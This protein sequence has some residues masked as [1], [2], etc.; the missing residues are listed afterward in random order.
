MFGGRQ[1][2]DDPETSLARCIVLLDDL[3]AYRRKDIEQVERQ[4]GAL[5]KTRLSE[6]YDMW[7]KTRPHAERIVD[8]P[9]QVPGVKKLIQAIGWLR[10]LNKIS[11]ILLVLFISFQIVPIWRSSL[12]GD[13]VNG[14]GLYI[15]LG[16]VLFV[17]ALLNVVSI[18]DYRTR[19]RIITYEEGTMDK[20]ASDREK[21]KEGVNRMMKALARE[22]KR[23][24]KDPNY[25][26]MVL[27]FDDYE[28]IEVVDK[29]RPK[30]LGIFKKSYSHFQ[31]IPKA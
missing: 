7:V 17:V 9:A 3:R 28:N 21:M 25:F 30:S 5:K 31:V 22:S 11:M 23:S 20:Y 2:K 13:F 27:Y 14:I 12:G 8:M 4:F 24:G 6:Y 10:L 1:T 16:T 26:G 18:L 19:K 29:W 15:L